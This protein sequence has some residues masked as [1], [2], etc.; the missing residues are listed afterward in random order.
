MKYLL[1]I[2]LFASPLFAQE[3]DRW[4]P[5]IN[6]KQGES[7]TKKVRVTFDSHSF[8]RVGNIV[9][10]WVKSKPDDPSAYIRETSYLR[11][12][13]AFAFEMTFFRIDC[14]KNTIQPV[15]GNAYR[16]DGSLLTK[17]DGWDSAKKIVPDTFGDAVADKVC[18]FNNSIPLFDG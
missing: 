14:Q 3:K 16:S 18:E 7:A 10:V 2:A 15:E 13:K 9:E 5:V 12:V 17:I 6:Y 8:K 11:R 4:R 1:L